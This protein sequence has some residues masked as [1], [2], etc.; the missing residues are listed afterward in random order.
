MEIKRNTFLDCLKF[1]LILLVILGHLLGSYKEA[2][3]LNM[4]V[5]NFIYLFH[6]P[7]FVFVSGYFTKSITF[8]KFKT[9]IFKI[10]ETFLFLHVLS[11]LPLIIK[12]TLT[13][14]SIITPW[15]ILW[16]LF[17]LIIWKSFYFFLILKLN[18]RIFLFISILVA[19]MSGFFSILGYPLSLSR[20]FVFFPFFLL[21]ALSNEIYL[22][23]IRSIPKIYG[24]L[25]LSMTFICLLFVQKDLAVIAWG[26][27]SY[28]AFPNIYI[29]LL[30]RFLFF[31]GAVSISIAFINIV[32]N[33]K[34]FSKTGQDTL[35]YY[36]YH[37]YLIILFREVIN[38]I[39]LNPNFILIFMLSIVLILILYVFSKTKISR[40][41]LNPYSYYKS[42]YII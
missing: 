7:L 15:W 1:Y 4:V 11:L 24:V 18:N 26:S 5:W 6:M 23:K 14:E 34:M 32:P 41:L 30:M 37:G 35:L 28:Y 12:G 10:I 2:S 8:K 19:L 36:A 22:N 31:I 3:H 40:Y 27:Y 38:Y 20:I 25:V 13:L 9:S 17:A 29:G 21:G 16:Y 33:N 39:G 42:K